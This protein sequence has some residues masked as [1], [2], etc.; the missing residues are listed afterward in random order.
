VRQLKIDRFL[1]LLESPST[2]VRLSFE[3]CPAYHQTPQGWHVIRPEGVE[4]TLFHYVLEGG[5]RAQMSDSEFEVKRHSALIVSPGVSFEFE[6]TRATR[7]LIGRFRLQV[8]SRGAIFALKEPWLHIVGCPEARPWFDLLIRER[9]MESGGNPS[10]LR[11]LVFG[12]FSRLQDGASQADGA[13]PAGLG[14]EE[15]VVV[16]R[17]ISD[18]V[19]GWITPREVAAAAGYS[20]DYFTRLFRISFGM[21]PREWIARER[22]RQA[23]V[24]LRES[25]STVTEVADQLGYRDVFFFSRQFKKF[26]GETPSTVR[27]KS[28]RAV[29]SRA[30][31]P[32]AS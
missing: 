8:V 32:A 28:R 5:F 18:R 25:R 7:P 22:V 20:L 21:S 2:T 9:L 19:S 3:R 24:L 6:P 13:T 12:L 29:T 14:A 11:S 17:F 31:R 27:Q 15:V 16:Q 1:D 26:T 4:E 23:E 30:R 10:R